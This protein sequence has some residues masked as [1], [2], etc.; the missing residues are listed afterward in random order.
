MRDEYMYETKCFLYD[1]IEN[2]QMKICLFHPNDTK[3][4]VFM[5][6]N[7]L[8]TTRKRKEKGGERGKKGLLTLIIFILPTRDTPAQTPRPSGTVFKN[9]G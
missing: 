9:P 3:T 5:T 7:S 2:R 1:D 6:P 8:E 4:E